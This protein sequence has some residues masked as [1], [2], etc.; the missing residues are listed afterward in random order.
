MKGHT[1]RI[2][3]LAYSPDGRFLV[4]GSDDRSAQLWNLAMSGDKLIQWAEIRFP[5]EAADGENAPA[6]P[7]LLPNYPNPF[8][9]ETWIPFDLA[10]TSRVR[11][12][13][14]NE[15]GELTRELNL[16]TLQPGA[17]RSRQKAAYWDGRNALGERAASGIYF[18]RI[19]TE[20]F[21]AQRRMLLLK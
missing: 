13:I 1:G 4:S 18:A 12:L 16:G 17:Y 14:Y 11:I 8:N 5:D 20:T 9:P 19:Q 3:T 10:E 21:T 7:A 15:A 6:A 2:Y